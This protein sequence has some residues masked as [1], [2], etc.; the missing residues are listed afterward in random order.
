[1]DKA[2]IGL[3]ASLGIIGA[4]VT[5][6]SNKVK[7]AE[8][9]MADMYGRRPPYQQGIPTPTGRGV[10]KIPRNKLNFS[11]FEQDLPAIITKSN[12]KNW[13]NLA[14]LNWTEITEIAKKGSYDHYP[15]QTYRQ[16]NNL[17]ESI[18]I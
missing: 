7:D 10:R 3:I 8:S 5:K 16:L 17:Y 18:Y 12:I 13:Q 15:E 2:V 6:T 4:V 11:A 14:N 9:F 1:M